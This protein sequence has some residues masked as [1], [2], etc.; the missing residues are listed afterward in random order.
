MIDWYHFFQFQTY[1][2][3]CSIVFVWNFFNPLFMS[4]DWFVSKM[5]WLS[6]LEWIRRTLLSTIIIVKNTL[7]LCDSSSTYLPTLRIFCFLGS[8]IRA[9]CL[10]IHHTHFIYISLALSPD[11]IYI[12]NTVIYDF[13]THSA[14]GSHFCTIQLTL[15]LPLLVTCLIAEHKRLNQHFN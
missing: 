7:L 6:N 2:N 10:F 1:T 8:D 12:C 15:F 9:L 13:S 14:W 11:Y 4:K 3:C 5:L